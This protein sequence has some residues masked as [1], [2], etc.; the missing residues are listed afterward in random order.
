MIENSEGPAYPKEIKMGGPTQVSNNTEGGKH[1]NYHVFK[2][3]R[4]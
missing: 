3:Q 1:M 2:P 4:E